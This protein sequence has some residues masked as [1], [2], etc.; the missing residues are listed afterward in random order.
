MQSARLPVKLR[1]V[2]GS[3]WNALDGGADKP[4]SGPWQHAIGRSNP[5]EMPGL[6]TCQ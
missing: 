4:P 3:D 1:R 6:R 5:E 2:D